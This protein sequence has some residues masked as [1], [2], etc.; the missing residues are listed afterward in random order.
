MPQSL[1]SLN[2]H[3]VFST[4]NRQPLIDAE[5]QYYEF[6]AI[7]K[8]LDKAAMAELRKITS[9][10]E[11]TPTS[12]INEYHWGDFGGDPDKLMEGYFD[13]F[14]YFANWGTHELMLRVPDE[15]LDAKEVKQYCLPYCLEPRKSKGHWVLKVPLARGLLGGRAAAVAAWWDAALAGC[16]LRPASMSLPTVRRSCS[17]DETQVLQVVHGLL[18]ARGDQVVLAGG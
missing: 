7:D 12:L 18:E 17:G 16:R 3:L 10:A 14:L 11:I 9:R 2:F 8:P 15:S 4:K 6:R 5:L 1:A 13:A